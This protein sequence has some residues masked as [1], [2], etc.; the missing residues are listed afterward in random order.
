MSKST[1]FENVDD[2][3]MDIA[4][5]IQEPGALFWSMKLE[6]NESKPI[7]QPAIEGYIVHITHA[8]FGTNIKN[9][10]RTVVMVN[11]TEEEADSA[12]V[13]VLRQG[14]HEN[15]QLDLLFNEAAILSVKGSKP[16]PVFLTGYIQPP[17]DEEPALNPYDED[18]D[19]EQ[20][21]AMMRAKAAELDDDEGEEA[22]EL[23]DDEDDDEE[24]NP[25]PQKKQK[26]ASG[27]KVTKQNKKENNN[28]RKSPQQKP[29]KSPKSPQQ[30][31]KKA[32]TT[33]TSNVSDEDDSKQSAPK[34]DDKKTKKSKKNKKMQTMKG[35]LKYRDM[36]IGD[37]KVIQHGQSV[38][39]FYVG[40]M[41]DKKVFDKT[42]HGD[43]FEFNFGKGDVIKGWDLGLKGMKVG[44][45]R[46]LIIPSKLAYG[47]SGSP[48][49]I[50]PNA[51]LT[52][53][54]EVKDAQ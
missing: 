37:G 41:D 31:P 17:V 43:G 26:T 9:G 27:A 4:D 3:D 2:E 47:T 39:V 19:Q 50:P 7:D 11:T 21:E 48:P 49:Q 12:P 42:I 16:C 44:G 22:P 45:K 54:I 40:Q 36:K 38:K 33:K 28:K 5:Y 32:A 6:P 46:K 51:Q 14:Q 18:Y 25:P 8:C 20:L 23:V 35:G 13:C 10:S 52:F 30:K 15:Q 34:T 29:A 24:I 53:T 1:E